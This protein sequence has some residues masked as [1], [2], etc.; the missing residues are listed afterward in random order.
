MNIVYY[1]SVHTFVHFRNILQMYLLVSFARPILQS[2]FQILDFILI[3]IEQMVFTFQIHIFPLPNSVFQYYILKVGM[4][5][6]C[7][8]PETSN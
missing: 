7:F 3:S 2:N 8:L 6:N 1:K 5:Q 4:F